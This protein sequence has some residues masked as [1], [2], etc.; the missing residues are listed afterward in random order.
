LYQSSPCIRI[1]LII[2]VLSHPS[3]LERATKILIRDCASCTYTADLSSLDAFFNRL[4]NFEKENLFRKTTGTFRARF[5]AR[6]AMEG[7]RNY[8]EGNRKNLF[9]LSHL[10]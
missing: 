5:I 7:R 1:S 8:W 6:F 4:K 3:L 2:D 9:S 10:S